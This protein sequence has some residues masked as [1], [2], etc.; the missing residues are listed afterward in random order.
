MVCGYAKSVQRYGILVN[1][2]KKATKS[3]KNNSF[4]LYNANRSNYDVKFPILC[5]KYTVLH[6][7][8]CFLCNRIYKLKKK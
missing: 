7:K 6:K 2:W 1:A 5:N 8:V 3:Q 4:M